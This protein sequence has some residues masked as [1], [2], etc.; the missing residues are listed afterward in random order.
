MA[1]QWALAPKRGLLP[2]P[3]ATGTWAGGPWREGM[4]VAQGASPAKKSPGQALTHPIWAPSQK[5]RFLLVS[6][7]APHHDR[8]HPSTSLHT[9]SL[10]DLTSAT[11]GSHC[12]AVN[13]PRLFCLV[14]WT[15]LHRQDTTR[16]RLH[17]CS[18]MSGSATR[19][20]R[21][22]IPSAQHGEGGLVVLSGSPRDVRMCLYA[23]V[24]SPPETMGDLGLVLVLPV[25]SPNPFLFVVL[26]SL[27]SASLRNIAANC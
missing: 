14:R 22:G 4:S 1:Q 12:N 19:L 17:A 7:A 9:A 21:L 23:R 5:G 26:F 11:T 16:P 20:A 2:R 13:T 10:P 6:A 24:P 25:S 18:F 3:S 15:C 27:S 8:D